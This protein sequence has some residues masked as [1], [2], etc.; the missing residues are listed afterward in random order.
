MPSSVENDLLN[1]QD[2]EDEYDWEEIDVPKQQDLEITIQTTASR[3]KKDA[4]NKKQGI[5]HAERLVRIDCHKIHTVSLLVNAWTRNKWIND[6]LLHARLLSLTPIS[7]QNAFGMIHKS[8]V[9]DQ[10]QRGRLFEAAI[11]QLAEWWS[12]FFEV[13]YEGHIRNRTYESVQTKLAKLGLSSQGAD[14]VLGLEDIQDIFGENG[15]VIRSEKSLMKHVLMQSGSRDTSAQLFTALC[16]GLGIPARL[17]VSLQS[18]PW[19]ANAGKPRPTYV[20]KPK[21]IK[22]KGKMKEVQ[23]V[24]GER[25]EDDEGMEEVEIP[26]TP[27]ASVSEPDAK[28]KGKAKVFLGD[29]QRLDGRPVPEKSEKAK[30]KEKAKPVITLRKAK[31]KGNV[32]GNSSGPSSGRSSPQPSPDPKTMPPVFWTEVF[33]RPDARWLP[34]DPVRCIVNK[35]KV[36]DPT[37]TAAAPAAPP[38]SRLFPHPYAAAP[39]TPKRSFADTNRENRM[40]YVLAFEEDGYARD[41]TRRYAKEF[42][43]R[44]AKVQGGSST[45][46]GGGK[47]REQ[48]WQRVVGGVSRPYRLHRDDVEDEELEAAQMMEGM[49]TTIAG[50]KDHPL[51]VLSRHLKQTQVIN[52]PPPDTPEL[53]KFRGEPVYPRSSVVS[54]KTAENWMRSEGRTVKEGCQPL[55]MV[56]L[57]AGT[58]GKM[59][60]LEVLR[61]ELREAGAGGG[62]GSANGEMMQGLYAR[63]QTEM[64][65]PDP[66]IDGK[67]PKNNFGNIDLYV[68]SMLPQGAVHIPFK[69]VAKIARKLGFDFAEAVTGFEFKK[70]RAFPVIEGVVVAKENEAPL[71]EAYWEAE[72]DAEEKARVKR[73]ERVLKQWT[74]L[75]QGLRI[76]QRLQEQY[77]T[78]TDGE[79]EQNLEHP[80]VEEGMEVTVATPSHDTG[81]GFLAGADEV[82][83]P[84]HLPKYKY[85]PP[86][87]SF[88]PAAGTSGPSV[89]DVSMAPGQDKDF[90]VTPVAYD[91]HTMDVD[92]EDDLE[93]VPITTGTG[94]P[95]TTATAP[96]TM[97]ELAEDAAK[98]KRG[99]DGGSDSDDVDIDT[100]GMYHPPADGRKADNAGAVK[101]KISPRPRRVL[102]KAPEASSATPFGTSTPSAVGTAAKRKRSSGTSTFRR[103]SART[104]STSKSNSRRR[105]KDDDQDDDE[106]DASAED[107]LSPPSPK[108]RVTSAVG[109]SGTAT[110]SPAPSTRTLRPRASKTPAQLREAVQ[111]EEAYR[112]ATAQ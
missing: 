5:S 24:S 100:E 25:N 44:V 59:R 79:P 89:H 19:Q 66:V 51:Y 50:F 56:K 36:F 11:T 40:V 20:R 9:P 31:S 1:Q 29:G 81:G 60:E 23:S 62:E 54:L 77:A 32:L 37:P 70:R 97:R 83:E 94:T 64:Y 8:R 2:S 93:E 3:P 111:Q 12:S 63:S 26:G 46:G 75:I 43:A 49:P 90:E 61:D 21:G 65:K 35:R 103:I 18:V 96:K 82:V 74:R 108:K 41:V 78:K 47:A 7:L 45:I 38:G 110:P 106:D 27:T 85:Q 4:A 33:S 22:S 58:I 105:G 112:R 39:V 88:A 86:M 55:K 107:D 80:A 48:W 42:G 92:S 30:G 53:G 67:I 91:L 73:E 13:T 34:V 109:T 84:F 98:F 17:V 16:R 69:G 15:E 99:G 104:K 95:S 76:R 14:A 52:P 68:P 28:G 87:A 10:N 72:Q 71:L 57:R 102:V 6:P 101:I